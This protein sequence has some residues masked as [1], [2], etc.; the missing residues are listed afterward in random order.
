MYSTARADWA[1]LNHSINIE[2]YR[3]FYRPIGMMV[4]VF[5]RPGD[6][7][8]IPGRFIPKTQKMVFDASLLNT[9]HYEILIKDKMSN[10]GKGVAHSST[11]RST[12]D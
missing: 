2:F 3:T 9:Q 7:S 1:Y 5:N 11:L 12:N 4:R 8:S 6:Q 10:P